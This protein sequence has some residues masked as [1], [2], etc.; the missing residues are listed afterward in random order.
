MPLTITADIQ[1]IT[2][3]KIAWEISNAILKAGQLGF[4]IDSNNF[5]IGDGIH[6]W[7]ELSFPNRQ[8]LEAAITRIENLEDIIIL[9]ADITYV[10]TEFAK[11]TKTIDLDNFIE[12]SIK[13]IYV[14]TNDLSTLVTNIITINVEDNLYSSSKTTALSANQ[15]R[16]LNTIKANKDDVPIIYAG[17]GITISQTD[18]NVT[19]TNSLPNVDTIIV[20][21]L[22]STS[23]TSALSAN[24]GRIIGILLNTKL[25]I[26]DLHIVDNLLSTSSTSVLSARQGKI[27]NDDKASRSELP[28]ILDYLIYS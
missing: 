20:D 26:S 9:K 6:K 8:E 21:A 16:I 5:K 22:T 13:N 23:T 17:N 10:D 4:A 15:G 7:N 27:L 3:N 1:N 2:N 28:S 11:Y 18:N 14:K 25:N 12:N 19:I 24:Q